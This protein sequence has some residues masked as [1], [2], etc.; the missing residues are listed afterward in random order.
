MEWVAEGVCLGVGAIA[1]TELGDF[2][3]SKR[4]IAEFGELTGETHRLA[5][6]PIKGSGVRSRRLPTYHRD[7]EVLRRRL[8]PWVSAVRGVR[9]VRQRL[10]SHR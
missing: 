4:M 10:G 9:V 3:T 2:E 7:D 8:R 5:G 1:V 6:L